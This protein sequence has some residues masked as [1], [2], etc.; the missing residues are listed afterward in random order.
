MQP[1]RWDDL[2]LFLAVH[3]T[4]TLAG[5]AARER[6]DASTVSRRLASFEAALGTTLFVRTPEGLVPTAAADA[7]VGPAER[8]AAAAAEVTA[9]VAGESTA[10][11]GTVRVA[12]AEGAAAHLVGPALPRLFERHPSLRLELVAAS[13]VADLT[14]READL[15]VRFVRPTHGDLVARRVAT[16]GYAAW[17]HRRYLAGRDPHSPDALDWIG[18]DEALDHLPEG[19]WL[20]RRGLRPRLRCTTMTA[21]F[22]AVRAGVGALVLP[23]G[24]GEIDPDLVRLPFDGPSERVDLWLV[25]HRALR[26]LPRIAAVWDFLEELLAPLGRARE[27]ALEHRAQVASKK[28]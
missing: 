26:E 22:A 10:I 14:R 8:A 11:E 27:A 4:R 18:W 12:V 5:A 2:R 17:A 9:A 3:R 1:W 25:S 19:R 24:M 23:D 15:A 13:A 7:L 6:V 20:A 16:V 21:T 28:E